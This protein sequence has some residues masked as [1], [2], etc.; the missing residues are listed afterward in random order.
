[1]E[2]I[3]IC[4]IF[5]VFIL[6]AYTLGLKNGQKISNKEEIK[7]PIVEK[8]FEKEL[9]DEKYDKQQDTLMK[10]LENIEIYDGTSNGQKKVE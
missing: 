8:T 9:E 5:G 7:I 4:T 6:A 1:M 2:I 3:G 10:V